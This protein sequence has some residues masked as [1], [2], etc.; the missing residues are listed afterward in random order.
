MA[1]LTQWTWIWVNSGSWW[2]T[3]RPG[4]LRFI[5]SQRVGPYWVTELN[6]TV[7]YLDNSWTKFLDHTEQPKGFSSPSCSSMSHPPSP[8]N[9]NFH[10]MK[11]YCSSMSIPNSSPKFLKSFLILPNDV[12]S[13]PLPLLGSFICLL[14]LL[15]LLLGR[16]SRVRLCATP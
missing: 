6:W 16:F 1:S 3:R 7:S 12:T 8:A 2:W 14:L 11:S 4:M 15:L 9:L 10:L 5:G 13:S